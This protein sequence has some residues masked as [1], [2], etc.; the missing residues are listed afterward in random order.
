MKENELSGLFDNH[1]V[2]RKLTE[3][4]GARTVPKLNITGLSGSS[5]A[6]ALSRVFHRTSLTHVVMLPK[7]RSCLFLQ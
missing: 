2:I 1:P 5:G 4:I 3:V 7:R 6:M